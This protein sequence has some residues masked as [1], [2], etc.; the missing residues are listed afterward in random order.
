MTASTVNGVPSWKVTPSRSFNVHSVKSAFGVMDSAKYGTTSPSAVNVNNGSNTAWAIVNPDTANA[1]AVGL[2]PSTS[3]SRPTRKVP[4][5]TGSPS[6]ASVLGASDVPEPSVVSVSPELPPSS[7]PPQATA[8]TMRLASVAPRTR[9]ERRLYVFTCFPLFDRVMWAR[10][11]IHGTQ[12]GHPNRGPHRRAHQH[13]SRCDGWVK[14]DPVV[15]QSE[16]RRTNPRFGSRVA[17]DESPG[18]RQGFLDGCGRQ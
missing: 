6:G 16:I 13:P 11:C 9:P 18:P 1:D 5:T 12:T 10:C 15:D 14:G 2:R 17:L 8:K 4:P 3:A 7:P